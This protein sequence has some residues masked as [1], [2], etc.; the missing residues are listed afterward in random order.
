VRPRG[1]NVAQVAVQVAEIGQ[2]GAEL[3]IAGAALEIEAGK[4][5]GQSFAI[6]AHAAQRIADVVVA[7]AEGR[8]IVVRRGELAR[9]PKQRQRGGETALPVFENAAATIEAELP[10]P[11]RGFCRQRRDAVERFRRLREIAGRRVRVGQAEEHLFGQLGVRPH[12]RR[13]ESFLAGGDRLARLVL[14]QRAA[15]RGRRRIRRR[16]NH[17][18]QRGGEDH[19]AETLPSRC[20]LRRVQKRPRG[21]GKNSTG[22]ARCSR[23]MASMLL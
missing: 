20:R 14:L 4:I 23:R 12:L 21:E 6:V 19:A 3:R 10:H 18:K 5:G 13:C 22:G 2:Q 11:A 8:G 1:R 15:T 16:E 17:G 9:C 7:L